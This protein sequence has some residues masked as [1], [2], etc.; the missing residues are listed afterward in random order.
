MTP[1][2]PLKTHP[3][4]GSGSDDSNKPGCPKALD[5]EIANRLQ[6]AREDQGLS[7]DEIAARIGVPVKIYA[8][9]EAAKRRIDAWHLSKLA[10]ALDLPI[11]WFF[12]P[13]ADIEQGLL[14]GRVASPGTRR[15]VRSGS[16]ARLE[17]LRQRLDELRTKRN[18]D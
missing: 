12:G 11:A 2:E 9:L 3:E 13:P 5:R 14:K 1:K 6:M 4:P 10:M 15:L 7:P 8:Q 18:R 16:D 17:N